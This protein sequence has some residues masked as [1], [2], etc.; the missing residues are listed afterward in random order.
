MVLFGWSDPEGFVAVSNYAR[1]HHWHLEMRAY[2]TDMVPER[3]NGDGILYSQGIRERIDRFV[4]DQAKRCPVVSLNANLPKG[5]V[6]PVVASDNAE[7]GRMAARHLL[8]RG[9]RDFA[10]YSALG[11][12]VSDERR[13]GFE[14]VIRA[15]GYRLHA[16]CPRKGSNRLVP[17]SDQR[18]RLAAQL[19]KLPP[20]AGVLALDDLVA[21]EFIEIALEA[22]RRVPDDLAVVG[23]G[24]LSA[25]CECSQIPITSIDLRSTEVAERA[26][27]M[28]DRLMAR[29]KMTAGSERLAPG[30]LVVRESSDTTVV[31]DPRLAEAIAFMTA[32]LRK[33]LSLDQAA[34]AAGISRRTLYHLFCDDLGVTPADY[35]RRQRTQLADRLLREH[36][37]MT[38]R[39]AAGKAGFA[40]TRSLSRSLGNG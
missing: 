30:A 33:S 34:E 13:S 14:E 17:W 15:S 8:E 12:I 18:R 5:L 23:M 16:I 21:S 31:R 20:R 11:G 22:G 27:A 4:I 36:P 26:A 9:H 10:Y 24:N 2:F 3:W 19:R 6:V 39:E 1:E 7:A 28:L 32:N 40:S 29:G 37:G 38:R 25:V 35:L